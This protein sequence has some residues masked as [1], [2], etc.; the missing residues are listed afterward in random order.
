LAVVHHF[1]VQPVDFGHDVL[2]TEVGL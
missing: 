1:R 2:I